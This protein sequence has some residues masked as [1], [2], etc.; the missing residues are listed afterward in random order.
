ARAAG[1]TGPHGP[2]VLATKSRNYAAITGKNMFFGLPA[3]ERKGPPVEIAKFVYL[4]H[5]ALGDKY[6]EAFLN[7]RYNNVE[8]R[9]RNQQG[10]NQ[11]TIRDSEREPVLPMKAVQIDARDLVFSVND[12]YYKMHIGQ[13]IAEAMQR[14]LS[15]DQIESLP[16]E[17]AD[18]SKTK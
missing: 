16:K 6:N 1:P 13:N 5:I 3:E 14:P 8:M 17:K 12:K 4:T 11:I 10:L 18:A 9:L 2:G 15:P 7:D